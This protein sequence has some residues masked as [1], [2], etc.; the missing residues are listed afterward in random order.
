MIQDAE[1]IRVG[2]RR[3]IIQSP[4]SQ[5]ANLQILA[6]ISA[7]QPKIEPLHIPP[8]NPEAHAFW[9]LRHLFEEPEESTGQMEQLHSADKAKTTRKRHRS[10]G[11]EFWVHLGEDHKLRDIDGYKSN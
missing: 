9:V 4:Y 5:D 10:Y 6:S 3:W 1:W 8:Y 11:R 2:P 7:E